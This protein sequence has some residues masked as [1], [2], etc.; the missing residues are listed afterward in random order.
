MNSY[1]GPN[2]GSQFKFG[3]QDAHEDSQKQGGLDD[4]HVVAGL[5]GD[6]DAMDQGSCQKDRYCRHHAL[7]DKE[8]DLEKRPCRRRLPDKLEGATKVRG[9]S[10]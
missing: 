2:T 9:L 5:D 8:R 6:G 7:N 4:R 3:E 1:L 10:K